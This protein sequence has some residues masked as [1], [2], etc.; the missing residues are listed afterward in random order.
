MILPRPPREIYQT[1]IVPMANT[2][3]SIRTPNTAPGHTP[4]TSC[5]GR[6]TIPAISDCRPGSQDWPT[7]EQPEKLVLAC[8]SCSVRPSLCGALYQVAVAATPFLATWMC[9]E[10]D[11]ALESCVRASSSVSDVQVDVISKG[12]VGGVAISWS[13][14][15]Y[16]PSTITGAWS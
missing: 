11:Q 2:A 13:N 4:G 7:F 1:K 5:T 9:A 15:D 10:R 16:N 14:V 3:C 8:V 12:K 6:D